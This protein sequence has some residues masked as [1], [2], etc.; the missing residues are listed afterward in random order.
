[1]TSIPRGGGRVRNPRACV[2][3]FGPQHRVPVRPYTGLHLP[4]GR[5]RLLG[6]RLEM[7]TCRSK[8]AVAVADAPQATT[9]AKPKET[10]QSVIASAKT[11]I[12][13]SQ[14]EGHEGA[15]F[16]LL[17]ELP[18]DVLNI[19]TLEHVTMRNNALTVLTDDIRFL[20]Q[21]K[22]LDVSQNQLTLLPDGIGALAKLE[23]LLASENQLQVRA[24]ER[25]SSHDGR[26]RIDWFRA[27]FD[28]AGLVC[29]CV[30]ACACRACRS[31][32]AA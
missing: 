29:V 18:V 26:A 4:G 20:T 11:R 31:A 9:T 28:A 2:G 7:G 19:R 23:Q 14:E 3:G 25:A 10:L 12:N 22:F 6:G 13:L 8:A 30:R 17:K 32:S 16:T 15:R 1:M 24:Q 5:L 27:G 21:L